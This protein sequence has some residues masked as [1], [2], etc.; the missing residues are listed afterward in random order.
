MNHLYNAPGNYR[1]AQIR[2]AMRALR[3]G[4]ETMIHNHSD[5]HGALH[6]HCTMYVLDWH[7]E[8]QY[9][10]VHQLAVIFPED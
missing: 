7:N 2:E 5:I 1:D 10:G 6:S 4:E 9:A 8:L 3:S